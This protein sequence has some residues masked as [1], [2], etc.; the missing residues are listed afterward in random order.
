MRTSLAYNF[1]IWGLLHRHAEVAASILVPGPAAV[2]FN[3]LSPYQAYSVRWILLPWLDL[4]HPY[5]TLTDTSPTPL[6]S[7]HPAQ[8]LCVLETIF[9]MPLR[10]N[11]PCTSRPPIDRGVFPLPTVRPTRRELT[12]PRTDPHTTTRTPSPTGCTALHAVIR[13]NSADSPGFLTEE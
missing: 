3:Y 4:N 12:S 1:T 10:P 11:E 9:A 6:G 7:V 8:P 13:A 5:P 2:H